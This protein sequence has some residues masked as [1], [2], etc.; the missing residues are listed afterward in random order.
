MEMVGFVIQLLINFFCSMMIVRILR[1]PT[2]TNNEGQLNKI[3]RMIVVHLL[4]FCFC[5]V[6][7]NIILVFYTLVRRKNKQQLHSGN[8]KD[9]LPHSL[10]H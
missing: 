7:Y 1:K 10:F 8:S 6:P 4:I 2:T 3:L 5:F 9:H